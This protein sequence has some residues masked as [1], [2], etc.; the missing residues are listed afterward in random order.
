[1]AAEVALTTV[2]KNANSLG[3]ILFVLKDDDTYDAWVKI[4]RKLSFISMDSDDSA[5]PSTPK[6]PGEH[7]DVRDASKKSAIRKEIDEPA[8]DDT[9]ESVECTPD[10]PKTG[11]KPEDAPKG[12]KRYAVNTEKLIVL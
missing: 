11:A 5:M 7:V 6:T 12:D 8:S 10:Q 1:M 4:A 9:P 2:D 3:T